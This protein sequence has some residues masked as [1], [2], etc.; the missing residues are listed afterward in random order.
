M[1]ALGLTAQVAA[2]HGETI[3]ISPMQGTIT[4]PI[5]VVFTSHDQTVCNNDK[6][7]YFAWDHRLVVLHPELHNIIS[8][9]VA[10]FGVAGT[11]SATGQITPQGAFPSPGI[12]EKRAHDV[13][14]VAAQGTLRDPN[15]DVASAAFTLTEGPAPADATPSVA[16][17][18]PSGFGD[19][20]LPSAPATDT[21]SANG[22]PSPAALAIVGAALVVLAV[23][24]WILFTAFRS[25]SRPRKR[26]H[27]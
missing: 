3:S 18:N 15:G 27:H 14:A 16:A 4:T 7:V 25:G 8:Q 13:E 21:S 23:S 26:R 5:T 2:A 11:C 20:S 22:T 17:V 1:S 6:L 24:A 10:L 9:S 12:F 19:L